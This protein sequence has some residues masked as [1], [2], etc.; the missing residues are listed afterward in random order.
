LTRFSS[1]WATLTCAG[2]GWA[3]PPDFPQPPISNSVQT[4]TPAMFVVKILVT[5]VSLNPNATPLVRLFQHKT[6][7]DCVDITLNWNIKLNGIDNH[8]HS[9]SQYGHDHMRMQG[10]FRQAHQVRRKGRSQE[11]ARSDP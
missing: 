2:G 10:R 8:S 1:T 7:R 9:R 11:F 4:A 6:G 3:L 5:P